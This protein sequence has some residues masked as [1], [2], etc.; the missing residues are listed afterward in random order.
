MWRAPTRDQE[1]GP[2]AEDAANLLEKGRGEKETLIRAAE[3]SELDLDQSSHDCYYTGKKA[4][5]EWDE[6][7]EN[8]QERRLDR[9]PGSGGVW[10][11][12]QGP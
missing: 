11:M 12:G 4:L 7:T 1:V 9:H 10:E 5:A 8:V 6:G 3:Q 2:P